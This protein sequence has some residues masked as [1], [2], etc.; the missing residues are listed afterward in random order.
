MSIMSITILPCQKQLLIKNK[1]SSL[2]HSVK[3]FGREK[4]KKGK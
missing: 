3:S 4:Q 2:F 1:N